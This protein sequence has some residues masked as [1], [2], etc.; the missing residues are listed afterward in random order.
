MNIVSHGYKYVLHIINKGQMHTGVIS[1]ET[2][3]NISLS[4][5]LPLSLSSLFDFHFKKFELN[6]PAKLY[7]PPTVTKAECEQPFVMSLEL[8]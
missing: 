2:E 7:S 5:P 8:G 3:P 6:T 4:N 1:N